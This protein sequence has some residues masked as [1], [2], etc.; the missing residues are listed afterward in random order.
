MDRPRGI[1]RTALAEHLGAD[2]DRMAP[3]LARLLLIRVVDDLRHHRDRH[4]LWV[5][6][7]VISDCDAEGEL[8]V[9][10]PTSRLLTRGL[11]LDHDIERDLTDA[12]TSVD[13]LTRAIQRGNDAYARYSG[14]TDPDTYIDQERAGKLWDEWQA[15]RSEADNSLRSLPRDLGRGKPGP[16]LL[17]RALE[18]V[19]KRGV[20]YQ[21][22][23]SLFTHAPERAWRRR[24]T[25]VL[26]DAARVER[27]GEPAPEEL[28][29]DVRD[30]RGAIDEA[31]WARTAAER[32]EEIAVPVFTGREP[33]TATTATTIRLAALCLAVEARDS[34]SGDAFHRVVAGVTRME[35]DTR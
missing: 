7:D 17:D 10:S 27:R 1:D 35:M 32:L 23:Y 3:V 31:S 14:A 8:A 11:A 9:A 15:D 16:Y 2:V 21:L 19:F 33:L 4:S 24:V 20:F 6:K 26:V 30:G 13:R 18:R 5:A 29:D 12:V 22:R 34:G 25:E 28:A